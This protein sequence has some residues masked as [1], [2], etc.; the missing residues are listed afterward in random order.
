MNEH[1]FERWKQER[2]RKMGKKRENGNGTAKRE[3]NGTVLRERN[4]KKEK[5]LENIRL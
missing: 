5:K 2:K 3:N 1:E 4:W